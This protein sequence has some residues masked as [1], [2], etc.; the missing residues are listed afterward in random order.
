MR[1]VQSKSVFSS[2]CLFLLL[3]PFL[4]L[5]SGCG[6]S[7]Y[8]NTNNDP[9]TEEVNALAAPGIPGA[10]VREFWTTLSKLLYEDQSVT[11]KPINGTGATV[12]NSG[13]SGAITV[14]MS[15]LET[16]ETHKA[17]YGSITLDDSVSVTKHPIELKF[18]N[19]EFEADATNVILNGAT[20]LTTKTESGALIQPACTLTI[21]LTI[22]TNGKNI[23]HVAIEIPMLNKLCEFSIEM[24]RTGEDEPLSFYTSTWTKKNR[25]FEI[26][27]PRKQYN[28]QKEI[29]GPS[30][31]G[32]DLLTLS[33][34][35]P[36]TTAF[37]G[38][39]HLPA[40]LSPS[41]EAITIPIDSLTLLTA[42]DDEVKLEDRGTVDTLNKDGVSETMHYLLSLKISK[43]IILEAQNTVDCESMCKERCANE[44]T[45]TAL[46]QCND[47][48][49]GSTC[50]KRAE[51][52]TLNASLELDKLNRRTSLTTPVERTDD[53]TANDQNG[54]GFYDD[55]TGARFVLPA[56]ETY[57]VTQAESP[58]LLEN[59]DVFQV[60]Y[61]QVAFNLRVSTEG[62]VGV[63]GESQKQ[64]DLIAIPDVFT[65]V[66]I[67][68]LTI[69]LKDLQAQ[70]AGLEE[71][72]VLRIGTPEEGGGVATTISKNYQ[73]DGSDLQVDEEGLL[74]LQVSHVENGPNVCDAVFTSK[75][76]MTNVT[77]SGMEVLLKE[78]ASEE[79]QFINTWDR[80]ESPRQ[81]VLC[82]DTGTE[83]TN[84]FFESDVSVNV[85]LSRQWKNHQERIV[86]SGD[87]LLQQDVD[88]LAAPL[89][90]DL[91]A[92]TY[93]DIAEDKD[94]FTLIGE[95][96]K[97]NLSLNL[98]KLNG[99]DFEFQIDMVEMKEG[100]ETGKEIYL[101]LPAVRK[102]GSG[103]FVT[104]TR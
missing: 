92:N 57:T 80:V 102:S 29:T 8:G 69:S 18:E 19:F 75:D 95:D 36:D 5:L 101:D 67:P 61:E 63:S 6:E 1:A 93:V 15:L 76:G 4:T 62:F 79:N 22:E 90:F 37:S 16:D 27:Y 87:V 99:N 72:V 11:Y 81:P 70:V 74:Y 50:V 48:C 83:T 21:N 89:S 91:P 26:S 25:T 12:Q 49:E 24:F 23:C 59:I 3:I 51:R 66:G 56:G 86:A 54:D 35:A 39:F 31:D 52:F 64:T 103:V 30:D 43:K 104:N 13:D 84:N 60:P 71:G 14:K 77:I 78:A 38:S 7:N 32:I 73:V 34:N 10:R 85:T 44:Y 96:E 9:N 58:G 65:P 45:G 88:C 41:G 47:L 17:A 33:H 100:V 98:V 53:L 82:S 46:A 28:E 97:F 2:F 40:S 42:I 55:F 20:T 68:Y 94:G